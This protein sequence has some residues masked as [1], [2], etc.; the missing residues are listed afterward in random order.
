VTYPD[1]L[2]YIASLAPRGWRLGLDRMAEFA[3]RG[4]LLDSSPKFVHVA[5]TNG[6]GSTTAMLQSMMDAQGFR[7]GSFFSPYVV[8]P[9]ERIQFG[10]EM[11]SEQDFV[12]ITEYLRPIGESLSETEFGGVTEFEFKTAMGFE[13]FRRKECE[14]VALE[15][16]LGGR[17]DA[18][19]IID[20]GASAIVS[21]GLDHMNILGNTIE[22][23]A[24]EKS[25]VL[26][27]GRPGVVG[28]MAPSALA[29]IEKYADEVGA[30]LWRIDKEIIIEG[31]RVTTPYS[32]VELFPSLFGEIQ[33]HNAAVAYAAL[34]IAGGIRNVSLAI[35]GVSTAFLPGRFQ[36]INGFGGHFILDGAHN[37]DSAKV[38]CQML[39]A[40]G[41]E[42]VHC[43]TGML[44]GHDPVEFYRELAPVV[45][46]YSVVP[47]DFHRAQSPAGLAT[48]ISKLG[49]HVEMFTSI[50]AAMYNAVMT[51]DGE[52][53][54]KDVLVTG[55]FY[56]VG[57]TMRLLRDRGALP[58]ADRV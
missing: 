58:P 11:I 52:G 25:G 33:I 38:L 8:D 26:K 41:T 31:N 24:F 53:R 17:L 29:V 30:S 45:S 47:I 34:E 37:N 46:S 42:K 21:I 12:S 32:S 39:L 16:G 10:R 4:G 44:H 2:D 19:N 15:V 49:C 51:A 20:C 6:K 36:R 27:P 1:S 23:I 35:Q 14:W 13:Y 7:T 9:R 40:A 3:R 56:L 57:E 54:S 50:E 48:E 22:E 28:R 5:G 18:T 55:S 43:I